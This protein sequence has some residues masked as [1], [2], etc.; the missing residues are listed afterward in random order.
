[1]LDALNHKFEQSRS[2]RISSQI[3]KYNGPDSL[4]VKKPISEV[5]KYKG[6]NSPPGNETSDSTNELSNIDVPDELLDQLN[7]ARNNPPD[8]FPQLTRILEDLQE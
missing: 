3:S 2:S 1:V 5:E 8:L 4:E 6:P 7:R